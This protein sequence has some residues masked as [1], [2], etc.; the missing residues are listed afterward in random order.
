[1]KLTLDCYTAE[2]HTSKF[3]LSGAGIADGFYEYSLNGE[4]VGQCYVNDNEGTIA[5]TVAGESA[6]LEIVPLENGEN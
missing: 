4:R 2:A 5:L 3:D 1:M 6:V